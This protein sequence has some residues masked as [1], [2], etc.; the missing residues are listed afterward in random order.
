MA[1]NFNANRVKRKFLI[2]HDVTIENGF[3]K[4]LA[5]KVFATAFTKVSPLRIHEISAANCK[6]KKSPRFF[7]SFPLVSFFPALYFLVFF[8]LFPL[9]LSPRGQIKKCVRKMSSFVRNHFPQWEGGL[10]Q[11]RCSNIFET[12]GRPSA[13]F[14]D[15]FESRI[16]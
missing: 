16:Y 4:F 5:S 13:S 11:L 8:T 9:V 1:F 2:Q 3:A 15:A 14:H 7:C 6:V 10:L 12:I